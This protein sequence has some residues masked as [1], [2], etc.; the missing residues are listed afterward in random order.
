MPVVTLACVV[1][2]QVH[3]AEFTVGAAACVDDVLTQAASAGCLS[4]AQRQ[5]LDE[6]A[7]VVAVHGKLRGRDQ[8]VLDGERI[9]LLGPLTVD[10]KVA[11]QRRVAHR[12]AEQARDK[13]SPDRR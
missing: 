4:A 12:R 10:P 13:W 11:R 5:A 8:P 6:G 9:E 7:L 1:G 2:D 3:S